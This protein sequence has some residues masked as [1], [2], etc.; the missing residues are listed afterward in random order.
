MLDLGL[1]ATINSDDPAYFGGYLGAELDRRRPTALALTR[2]ELVTLAKNSFT[3][4]FLPPGEIARHLAE[5]D[6]YVATS[7]GL[8][9]Y[10][11]GAS[12][13]VSMAGAT[14]SIEPMPSTSTSLPWPW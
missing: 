3:G 4:S 13:A 8:S 11:R 10:Q 12:S 9:R 1:K 2:D 5:I 14:S 7:R 6:A